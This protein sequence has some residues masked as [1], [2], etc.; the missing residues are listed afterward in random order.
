MSGDSPNYAASGHVEGQAALIMRERGVSNARLLM[1]NPNGI[2]GYCTS[3]VP[4]LLP[5]GAQLFDQSVPSGDT[6]EVPIMDDPVEFTGD[7][8]VSLA[9]GWEVVEQFVKTGSL[10]DRAQWA[11]L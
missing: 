5:E 10:D 2:C 8:V 9:R 4:T 1:D 6:A 11:Q 3:H 7:F